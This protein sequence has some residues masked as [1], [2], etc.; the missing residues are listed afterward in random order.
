MVIHIYVITMRKL[1]ILV[2]NNKLI[3]MINERDKTIIRYNIVYQLHT[4]ED[5]TRFINNDEVILFGTA[6]IK[7]TEKNVKITTEDVSNLIA[8]NMNLRTK[9]LIQFKNEFRRAFNIESHPINESR[10]II[11]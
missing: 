4:S 8:L 5:I 11:C 6:T 10:C 7:F 3:L 1:S 9:E 2:E